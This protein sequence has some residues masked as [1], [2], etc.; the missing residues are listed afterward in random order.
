MEQLEKEEKVA[1]T[2]VLLKQL[3]P[4][5]SEANLDVAKQSEKTDISKFLNNVNIQRQ[6][7]Y[8]AGL[9]D[10]SLDKSGALPRMYRVVTM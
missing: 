7:S 6:I 1:L 3:Q 4:Y 8:P 5:L 10:L 2:L 9:D